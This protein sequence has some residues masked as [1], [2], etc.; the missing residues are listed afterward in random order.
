MLPAVSHLKGGVGP[1]GSLFVLV[2]TRV[3]VVRMERKSSMQASPLVQD[4]CPRF[5]AL[6]RFDQADE[7]FTPPASLCNALE[8]L[9]RS[10][11]EGDGMT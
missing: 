9:R 2:Q 10:E 8:P 3:T 11:K 6:Q 5:A 4:R 1:R 7:V